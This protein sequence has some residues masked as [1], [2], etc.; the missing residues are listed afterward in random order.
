MDWTMDWYVASTP[1]QIVLS[2]HR[3]T[4]NPPPNTLKVQVLCMPRVRGQTGDI[5][6]R[7]LVHVEPNGVTNEVVVRVNGT[8]EN[9]DTTPSV[10]QQSIQVSKVF[11]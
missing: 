1:S 2:L 7:G 9:C 3:S 11:R 4:L 10:S 5:R 8:V 6:V